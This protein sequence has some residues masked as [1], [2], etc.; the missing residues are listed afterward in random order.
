V[1]HTSHTTELPGD[2]VSRRRLVHSIL[3]MS[4]FQFSFM[5]YLHS[6]ISYS[7]LD[8]DVF[9]ESCSLNKNEFPINLK[10]IIK[11]INHSKGR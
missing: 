3:K 11:G 1:Q 9:L 7:S 10:A 4:T 2:F 5:K 8:A 6:P